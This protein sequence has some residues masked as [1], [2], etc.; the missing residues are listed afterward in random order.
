MMGGASWAWR[1]TGLVDIVKRSLSYV[2]SSVV[3]VSTLDQGEGPIKV[4]RLMRC[5]LVNDGKELNAQLGGHHFTSQPSSRRH[6]L[7][8]SYSL[9]ALPVRP[10]RTEV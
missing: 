10:K 1:S 8:R 9:E 2:L 4:S 6:R 5:R 7:S 3:G